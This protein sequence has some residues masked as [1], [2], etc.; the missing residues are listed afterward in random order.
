LIQGSTGSA[1]LKGYVET[2][3]LG[4]APT[5]NYVQPF[6]NEY[7]QA[8][9]QE[10]EDLQA[11]ARAYLCVGELHSLRALAEDFQVAPD[12]YKTAVADFFEAKRYEH[13]IATAQRLAGL[14]TQ[15]FMQE[16][17]LSNVRE[18]ER[19]LLQ[20]IVW[21]EMIWVQVDSIQWRFEASDR[22]S[23]VYAE[24]AWCQA[25]LGEAPEVIAFALARSKG[26]EFLSH[27]AESRRSLQIEGGLGEFMDQLR[28]ESRGA[29]RVRWEA[30]KKSRL[31]VD[32]NEAV[33]ISRQ[34]LRDIELRRRLLFPPP[35]DE[36]EQP[37]LGSVEAFLETHPKSLILDLTISRWGT[38]VLI[39][40]GAE[41]GVFAGR[42]IQALPIPSTVARV[43]VDEWSSAYF[44]YLKAPELERDDAR[45]RWANQTDVLLILS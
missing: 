22:F 31:D 10:T 19:V 20:A 3:F 29:E 15:R 8:L 41:T 16:V 2:D 5:A 17:D 34:Q 30:T 28:V 40:G 7:S 38:V 43:W 44:G 12:S 23:N 25:T 45:V 13:A 11:R 37:P 32:V 39:A 14:W 26:R 18:A 27:S 36:S 4:A 33:Q 21:I 42:S 35:S 24:V 9:L 1:K 6:P